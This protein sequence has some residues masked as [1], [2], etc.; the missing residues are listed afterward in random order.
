MSLQSRR[1][2]LDAHIS[3]QHPRSTIHKLLVSQKTSPSNL[4]AV[5]SIGTYR[6]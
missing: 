4:K 6:T 3:A 2:V 1:K 5:E